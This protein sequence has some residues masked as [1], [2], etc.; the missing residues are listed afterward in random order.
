MCNDIASAQRLLR[1]EGP[2]AALRLRALTFANNGHELLQARDLGQDFAAHPSCRDVQLLR[3]RL[4][5]DVLEV[6][7]DTAVQC[8]WHNLC[9]NRCGF[10]AKAEGAPALARLL[11]S[12]SALT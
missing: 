10:D 4:T 2:L 11:S 7:V 1:R 12:S 3:V 5:P 9:V 8:S 6:L